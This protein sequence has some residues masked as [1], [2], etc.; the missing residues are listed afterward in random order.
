M[1]EN[2][3]KKY[4]PPEGTTPLQIIALMEG[5]PY[6]KRMQAL[7]DHYSGMGLLEGQGA[8][9]QFIQEAWIR[10]HAFDVNYYKLMVMSKNAKHPVKRE[11]QKLVRMKGDD[12][13]EYI[14]FSARFSTI[15]KIGQE[16]STTVSPCGY[17]EE[18]IF[19]KIYDAKEME[20]T[21]STEL[22]KTVPL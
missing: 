3:V 4:V 13:K 6:A 18:P 5:T 8:E 14:R 15:N 21:E 16:L 7:Y 2:S 10:F 17:W 9:G 1:V 19:R 11:I 22:E 20:W 12:G